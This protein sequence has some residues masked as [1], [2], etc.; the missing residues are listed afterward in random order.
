M[1]ISSSISGNSWPLSA[2]NVAKSALLNGLIA[3]LDNEAACV[4]V[5]FQDA[6]VQSWV[7]GQASKSLP[8]DL[9][10]EIVQARDH[11]FA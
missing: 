4:A 9:I 6:A 3:E 10:L 1:R 11:V 5:P 7:S 8:V 2:E